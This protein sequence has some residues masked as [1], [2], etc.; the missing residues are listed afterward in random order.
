M[1][2][3]PNGKVPNIP[4]THKTQLR[5]KA[6]PIDAFTSGSTEREMLVDTQ[7]Q[8]LLVSLDLLFIYIY[9]HTLIHTLTHAYIHICYS[10]VQELTVFKLTHQQI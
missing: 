8:M 6:I 9:K 7:V 3:C 10:L 4:F 2:G 1:H 5:V